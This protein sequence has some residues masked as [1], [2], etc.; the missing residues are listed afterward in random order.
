MTT[1]YAPVRHDPRADHDPGAQRQ[2][3]A[4]PPA[5]R[6][7]SGERTP[8]TYAALA[9]RLGRALFDLGLDA[10]LAGWIS[11]TASGLAFAEL[12]VRC[13]DRLVAVL[14]DLGSGS[15]SGSGRAAAG[16]RLPGQL[17][18]AF[19]HPAGTQ[20]PGSLGLGPAPA[21]QQR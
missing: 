10:H 19:A 5:G 7:H 16:G 11:P 12:P 13:A 6:E 15:G 2:V 9:R 18:F 17:S 3:A 8:P 20:A 21:G 14:E 1:V 4:S